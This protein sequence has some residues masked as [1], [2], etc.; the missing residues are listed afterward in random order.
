[1]KKTIAGLVFV[2][3]FALVL[4]P[5]V[6]AEDDEPD[7]GTAS[8]PATDT[9]MPAAVTQTAAAPDADA[10]DNLVPEAGAP[11]VNEANYSDLE[12]DLKQNQTEDYKM[13]LRNAEQEI[14]FLSQ[15][16]SMLERSMSDLRNQ[17]E[18]KSSPF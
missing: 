11:A 10:Q 6:F 18:D 9:G 14:R 16:V 7:M 15:R 2:L 13:R 12:K 1:M 5:Q 8:V 17:V 3:L 4:A